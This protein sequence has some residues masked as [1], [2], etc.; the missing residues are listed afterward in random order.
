MELLKRAKEDGDCL[1]AAAALH[2]SGVAGLLRVVDVAP[3]NRRIG[4]LS[5]A[6]AK[7]IGAAADWAGKIDVTIALINEAPRPSVMP[8]F[9]EVLAELLDGAAAVKEIMGAAKDVSEL[10]GVL[11]GLLGIDIKLPVPRTTATVGRLRLVLRSQQLPETEEI[12]LRWIIKTIDGVGRL[13]SFGRDAEATVLTRLVGGVCESSGCRGGSGMAVALVK[14]A[15]TVLG[16]EIENLTFEQAIAQLCERMPTQGAAVNFLIAV[17]GSP[18]TTEAQGAVLLKKLVET[19][20]RIRSLGELFGEVLSQPE[21]DRLA[22]QL[23]IQLA[24]GSL[25]TELSRQLLLR[26]ETFLKQGR[27]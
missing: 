25:P 6:V 16:S 17:K 1:S 11:L 7:R 15:R 21:S 14:R 10:L 2:S 13:T 5:Y 3:E 23:A 19:F 26:L 9:D 22:K 27:Q 12:L 24:D 18:A 4:L 20:L 8:L